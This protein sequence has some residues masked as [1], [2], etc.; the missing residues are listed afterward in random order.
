MPWCVQRLCVRSGLTSCH[1]SGLTTVTMKGKTSSWGLVRWDNEQTANKNFTDSLQLLRDA[2]DRVWLQAALLYKFGH[3]H[4]QNWKKLTTKHCDSQVNNDD[5]QAKRAAISQRGP[6]VSCFPTN[7][8][9]LLHFLWNGNGSRDYTFQTYTL[10]TQQN[11]SAVYLFFSVAGELF[12][13][14]WTLVW[15]W[16][17]MGFTVRSSPWCW[18]SR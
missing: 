5:R 10:T 15:E 16:F 12:A 7:H 6:E 9:N 1:C 3:T 11:L 4:K 17:Y 2:F 18:T 14:V 8:K 13:R